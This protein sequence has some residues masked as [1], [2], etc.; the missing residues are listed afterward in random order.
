MPDCPEL[1]W[2]VVHWG[3]YD[4]E[5]VVVVEILLLPVMDIVVG[6]GILPVSIP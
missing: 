1:Y 3:P 2:G 4:V 5:A 6:N